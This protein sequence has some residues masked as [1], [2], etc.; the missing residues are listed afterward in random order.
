MM[1]ILYK[2]LRGFITR[3][4]LWKTACLTLI[5]LFS[6]NEMLGLFRTRLGLQRL[7]DASFISISSSRS[8]GT[9]TFKDIP[10][11]VVQTDW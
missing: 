5:F 10:L 6:G 2:G 9:T 4:V 3:K 11:N 7:F 1:T 8:H